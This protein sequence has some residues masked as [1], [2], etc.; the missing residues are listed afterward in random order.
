MATQT[1]QQ[2]IDHLPS[3]GNRWFHRLNGVFVAIG[4]VAVAIIGW[5][6]LAN[7]ADSIRENP[8]VTADIAPFALR[9]VHSRASLPL[10]VVPSLIC[11]LI[12]VVFPLSR[13]VSWLIFIFSSLALFTVFGM[14][15]YS[16]IMF[17]APLYQYQ[18][19]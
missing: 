16:F 13:S 4:A 10:L 11:G 2:A 7:I 19:M 1:N 3:H 15:L 18:P 17:I 9:C 6:A 12:L 8:E 5:I 14:V